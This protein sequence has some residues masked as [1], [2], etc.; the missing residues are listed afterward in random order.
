MW[1]SLISYFCVLPLYF[2]NGYELLAT[3]KYKCFMAISK[4]SLIVL[5]SFTIIY[6]STWGMTKNEIKVFKPISK[7]DLSMLLFIGAVLLSYAF[8][9]YKKTGDKDD[10]FFYQGALYGASGWYMGMATFL[11]LVILYFI[12]TRYF[13]YTLNFWVPVFFVSA[14]IFIWGGLNRFSI[15]PIEMTLSNENFLASVGNINWFAGFESVIAPL[16]F[17]MYYGTK[18][19]YTRIVLGVLTFIADG[20]ILLNGSDSAVMC[21]IVTMF[22]LLLVSL[23]DEKRLMRFSEEMLLFSLAGMIILI[24]DKA[25][26]DAKTK[27]SAFADIF[28]SGVSP[29]LIFVLIFALRGWLALCEAG[30]FKY[31]EFFKTKLAKL[32]LIAAGIGLL[33]FVLLITVNTKTDGALPIIGSMSAFMFNSDWGS[34]RGATWMTGLQV[35]KGMGF[36]DKLFGVGPDMFYQAVYNNEEAYA[37]SYERFGESRL[38]NAHN[39]LITILVNTGFLGLASFIYMNVAAIR[40]FIKRSDKNP[41]MIMFALSMIMYLA[42]NVFSFE[43]IINVPFYFLTIAL[44]ASAI[45]R[46]ER[47]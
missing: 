13:H 38:T 12:I 27:D 9:S 35:F 7:I 21:F 44:G 23:K 39:E 30:K 4:Y 3:N 1:A 46:D 22:V 16:I 33:L 45:V 37:I 40:E 5:G 15:Y 11:I 18:E 26:P 41:Y 20:M 34:N 25:A 36:K 31:P 32:L 10:F 42:N 29:F 6:F 43:Q 14:L 47:A 17:G 8:S 19:K 2:H 28:T 24:I